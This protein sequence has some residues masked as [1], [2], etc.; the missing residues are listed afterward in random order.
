MPRK[1]V[2]RQIFERQESGLRSWQSENVIKKPLGDAP[3][4]QKLNASEWPSAFVINIK[5]RHSPRILGL[6]FG[7]W[8]G[9]STAYHCKMFATDKLTQAFTGA[10]G[11]RRRENIFSFHVN[12]NKMPSAGRNEGQWDDKKQVIIGSLNLLLC[13]ALQSILPQLIEIISQDS[14]WGSK[15]MNAHL[16]KI[17]P[18]HPIMLA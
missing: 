13:P 12:S 1:N 16:R 9:R 15:L 3:L 10:T 4:W 8:N 2:M 5:R 7:L 17:F 18:I 6:L 14:K 11:N